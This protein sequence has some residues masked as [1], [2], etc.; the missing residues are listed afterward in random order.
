M[1][2]QEYKK[3]DAI[4]NDH[5]WF[6]AKRRFLDIALE[7]Y[8]KNK[9]SKILD[10]GCGTG[11]VIKFFKGKGYDICGVDANIDALN[12]CLEKKL[13][14]KKGTAENISFENNRFDVVFALDL[15]EHLDHPEIAV[16][17]INRILKKDGI[18]IAT[19]PAHQSLWSYHD[20]HLHH[21]KRYGKKDFKELL[22]KDFKVENISWIHS[23]ILLPAILIRLKNRRTGDKKTSDVKASGKIANLIMGIAYFFELAI[24][25]L[26]NRLP[27]GLSLLAIAR[28]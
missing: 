6:V 14:V 24:F 21:K 25:R 18:L 28:K 20:V 3:M 23:F 9:N 4:E 2:S 11:A 16:K 27:W 17:E 5:W 12:Y 13:N 8:A 10:L 26:F 22:Q 15:L 1:E 7:K 19:V